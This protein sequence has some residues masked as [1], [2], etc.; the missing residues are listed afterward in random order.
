MPP[1]RPV[2]SSEP[3][4][5]AHWQQGGRLT[6]VCLVRGGQPT[7]RLT[8][9]LDGSEAEVVKLAGQRCPGQP[10]APVLTISTELSPPALLVSRLTS[11][12]I[13]AS[14]AGANLACSAS[15]NNISRPTAAATWLSVHG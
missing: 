6:L 12:C 3:A 4:N 15:N 11:P 1:R 9:A 7:P 13:P 10:A 8:W 5:R 14:L 2:L